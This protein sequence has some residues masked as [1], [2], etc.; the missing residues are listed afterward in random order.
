MRAALEALVDIHTG[1]RHVAVLGDM[2]ELGSLSELAHFRI[3]ELVAR[4]PIECLVTVG[5]LGRRIAE[6]ARAEGMPADAV[7]ACAALEEA[8]EVLDDLLEPGDVVL[9]KAS[10][11]MGLEVLVEGIVQPRA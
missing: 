4:M 11:S 8:G 1:G 5:P 7:R 9:V 10:R 6:G 2:K 3:G